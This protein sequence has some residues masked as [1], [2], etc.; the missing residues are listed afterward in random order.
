MAA[1]RALRSHADASVSNFAAE[2]LAALE[3][4]A[5]TG[6]PPA[7]PTS[8]VAT[9]LGF[10]I[11]NDLVPAPPVG[12]QGAEFATAVEKARSI[13][14]L[15]CS[16]LASRGDFSEGVECSVGSKKGQ[17]KKWSPRTL[18]EVDPSLPCPDDDGAGWVIGNLADIAL[19]HNNS[20]SLTLG[21]GD[22]S[23]IERLPIPLKRKLAD[24]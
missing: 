19:A 1:L 4:S 21:R 5:E 16:R 13:E 9:F 2:T 8:L 14:L 3:P 7:C 20:D 11:L 24:N 10:S 15:I 18:E 12:A 23:V 22:G 17:P 6:L